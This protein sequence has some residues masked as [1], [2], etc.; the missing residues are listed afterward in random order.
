MANGNGGADA[1][2]E[3][4]DEL[5]AG[6]ANWLA[7]EE[8]V[9]ESLD[10]LS[11]LDGETD[12]AVEFLSGIHRAVKVWASWELWATLQDPGGGS[13]DE[14]LESLLERGV[15]VRQLGRVGPATRP[16]AGRG[17]DWRAFEEPDDE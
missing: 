14:L 5:P 3:W 12:R 2:A 17:T 8:V 1:P 13:P 15:D 9:G 10:A 11:A 16:R 4:F 6:L 7:V